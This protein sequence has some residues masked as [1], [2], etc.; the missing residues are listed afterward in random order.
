DVEDE[1]GISYS[2][3]TKLWKEWF[4]FG[5][6]RMISAQGGERFVRTLD[7]KEFGFE[8]PKLQSSVQPEDN[9]ST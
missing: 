2:T 4:G 6:G 5:L 3:I 8:V 7:L 9:Q 1:S